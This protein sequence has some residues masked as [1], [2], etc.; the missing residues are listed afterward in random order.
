V[1]ESLYDAVIARGTRNL[2]REAAARML[3]EMKT[4]A[5]AGVATAHEAALS[6]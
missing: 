5:E 6:S 4:F 1:H 2:A 3:V